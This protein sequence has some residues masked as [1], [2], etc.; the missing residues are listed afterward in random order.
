MKKKVIVLSLGGSLI[1]PDKVNIKLL[2]QFKAIIRKFYKTH[3]FVIVCGGG[4]IA[5]AYIE[6]LKKEHRTE[7]EISQA[8]IRA[9]RMNAMFMMQ[10][11]G[12]KEANDTLPKNMEEVKANLNTNNVV[13]CGALRWVPHSTSDSTAAKLASF[14][15]TD[16]INLT[17]IKGLYTSNPLV[18]KSAKFIPK[19]DWKTFEKRAHKHGFK[20]GQH[21]VLDQKASTIIREHKIKTYILGDDM[22]NL[23]NLLAGKRFIGTTISG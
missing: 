22:N 13:F 12:K 11:F 10:F 15:K 19:D 6:A 3:K 1:I 5:R 23:K 14:L 4:A 16:F 8:G 20:A 2:E 7:Y 18:H 17:N 21:F 9:T